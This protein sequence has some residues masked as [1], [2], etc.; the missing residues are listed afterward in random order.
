MQPR[1]NSQ[2]T[3]LILMA[4]IFLGGVVLVRLRL[5]GLPLERDEGEYAYMAQQLLQGVLPYTESHSMKFPGIYFVYAGILAI[6]LFVL[7]MRVINN[8]VRAQVNLLDGGDEALTRAMRVHGNFA[9]YVPFVLLLM[10]LAE[11]QGGSGLFIHVLGTVL[12]VCRL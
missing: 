5:L 1:I 7:S 8:R 2:K 3:S 12:I 4:G 11:I 10:A 6:V 9:E